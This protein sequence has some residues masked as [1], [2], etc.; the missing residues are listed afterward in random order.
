MAVILV[1]LAHA[2]VPGMSGGFV[3]VD[4][5]FVISGFVITRLLHRQPPR[6]VWRNL[7]TFY[8]RRIRRILP[9]ATLTMVATVFAAWWL[10][11]SAFP[12]SLLGDVRWASLFGANFRLISTSSDY[13]IPGIAPSLVTHFWSLAVEEQFYVLFPFL[14]FSLTWLAPR[15]GRTWLLGTVVCVAIGASAWWSWRSGLASHAV[16]AYYSPFTRFF[17]LALGALVSL[18]PTGLLAKARWLSSLLTLTGMAALAGA[19][20][21]LQHVTN[22][23][24]VAAWWPCGATAIMLWSGGHG[25]R[26]G[27]SR[28]LSWGA[29]RYVGDVS[30]SFYLFHFAWIQIPLQMSS[31]PVGWWWRVVEIAGA[32]LCAVIS[33]HVLE[34]PIRRWKRLD[35]D[36]LSVALLAAICIALSWNATLVVG[37]LVAH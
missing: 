34:N 18:V 3:G 24:G 26:F 16:A 9:A 15:R 23:P 14:V 13:F 27:P 22:F 28:L 32:F 8:A 33:Y 10:L 1:V 7:G 19:V 2:F 21:R 30:Y 6:Q 25:L 5:F 11:G 17:E 4:V 20:W 29:L 12:E 31:P 35:R 37:Y 36:G